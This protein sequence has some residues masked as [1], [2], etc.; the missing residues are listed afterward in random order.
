MPLVRSITALAD[1]FTVVTS[2]GVSHTFTSANL[3]AAQK[4]M[5][6]AQI[7]ALAAPLIANFLQG[8]EFVGLH[9]TSVVPLQGIACVSNAP[10]DPNWWQS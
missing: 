6:P 3:S 4:L 7:E 1:G 9:L 10:L 5:T 8:A 2:N